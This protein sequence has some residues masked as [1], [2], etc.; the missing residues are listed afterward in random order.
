[1]VK[2][3]SDKVRRNKETENPFV[4]RGLGGFCVDREEEEREVIKWEI[5]LIPSK[6]MR[7]ERR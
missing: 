2:W 6:K 3:L 1:M 7:G 5:A 4:W